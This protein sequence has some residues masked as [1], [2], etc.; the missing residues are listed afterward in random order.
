MP[1]EDL[2]FDWLVFGSQK[3]P[4]PIDDL[5][6][7]IR[8]ASFFSQASLERHGRETRKI[9]AYVAAMLDLLFEHG[10]L[11]PEEL[12]D[13]VRAK[14][15]EEAEQAAAE[16]AKNDSMKDWPSI[17]IREDKP[18][19]PEA[20]EE[21]VDCD[22]RMHICHAVCCQLRFPLSSDE[23]EKG[24]VKWDLGHPYVIRHSEEG[25]C[26]H[27]DRASGRCGVYDDRPR[28]CSR[29]TC[30]NDD[31]IWKDFDNMILNDEFLQERLRGDVFV[32]DAGNSMPDVPVA[33][34]EKPGKVGS[35]AAM[36]GDQ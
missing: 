10:V 8:R 1:E 28:V 23:I 32:F 17:V 12:G 11:K 30:R 15:A 29:Y 5:D 36:A 2:S 34:I 24:K 14:Q 20:P 3:N 9:E 19:A 16:R 35:V 21:P 7:Q 18:D 31:R 33:F 6:R 26:V 4:A 25:F 27:N 22:A 13:K